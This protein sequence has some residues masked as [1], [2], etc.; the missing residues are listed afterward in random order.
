MQMQ[1]GLT[2][3]FSFVHRIFTDSSRNSHNSSVYLSASL[4]Y[5]MDLHKG[6]RKGSDP[7]KGDEEKRYEKRD[8]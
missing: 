8:F 3:L 7:Q 6:L 2:P 4:L 1:W 5:I